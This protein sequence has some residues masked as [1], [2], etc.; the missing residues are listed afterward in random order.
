MAKEVQEIEPSAAWRDR[1]GYLVVNYNR[2]GL[3]LITWDKW[4]G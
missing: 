2:L 3:K 4:L 1:V